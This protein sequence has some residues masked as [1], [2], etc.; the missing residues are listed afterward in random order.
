MGLQGLTFNQ[1]A[2]EIIAQ[3]IKEQSGID[4]HDPK[5]LAQ[6]TDH[7]KTWRNN[8]LNRARKQSALNNA[9]EYINASLYSGNQRLD[10]I[11]K[12]WKPDMQ[13]NH[14]LAR[15]V[16]AKCFKLA[17]KMVDEPCKVLLTGKPGVG[18][19]SLATAMLNYLC[20]E[21]L[22]VMTVSTLELAGLMSKQ[23]DKTDVKDKVEYVTKLMKTVDVLLLDDFASESGM[24]NEAKS[25]RQDLQELLFSVA[26][27]R[28]N[29]QRN[30]VVGS[31]IITTN[32]SVSELET[33]YNP[34]LISRLMPHKPEFIVDFSQLNDVRV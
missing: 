18:K 6:M 13:T 28:I 14:L 4:V 5:Q 34:K 16:G 15:E 24:K 12:N 8:R 33:M 20:D 26:N 31:T 3:K 21:G 30:E 23:Y 11:F 17:R 19:T 1:K 9:G 27:S 7:V 29:L 32:T 10:F 2:R 22:T 25:V